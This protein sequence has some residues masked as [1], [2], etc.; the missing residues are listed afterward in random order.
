[1]KSWKSVAAGRIEDIEIPQSGHMVVRDAPRKLAQ[2]IAMISLPDFSGSIH[3]YTS[4]RAAYRNR[5]KVPKMPRKPSY[6][7]ST[8]V[9][10][11]KSGYGYV[12]DMDL[13]M[14]AGSE[15]ITPPT[16]GVQDMRCGNLAWRRRNS[17]ESSSVSP[18][19]QSSGKEAEATLFK[20]FGGF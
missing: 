18:S 5:T 11:A 2:Q 1:M 13:D 17:S 4:I 6:I 12:P 15:K 16:Q 10:T 7:L 3:N 19:R 8:P 14:L 9:L 20:V